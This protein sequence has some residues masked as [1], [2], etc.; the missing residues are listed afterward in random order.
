MTI[1][2]KNPGNVTFSE[3]HGLTAAD[4]DGDWH[5]GHR[6]RQA[7]LGA[8]GE[9]RRSRSD[10]RAGALHLQDRARIR[11]RPAAR[12][13]C[14]SSCTTVRAPARRIQTADLNKDGA[15]DIMTGTQARDVRVPGYAASGR[16]GRARTGPWRSTA[17]AAESRA[18]SP[19]TTVSKAHAR[20]FRACAASACSS[21]AAARGSA[22]AWSARSRTRRRTSRS[23]T[24]TPRRRPL[25]RR[26]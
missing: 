18:S 16:P 6:H 21:P 17:I 11:R 26:T 24:S 19:P 15:M 25:S 5:S 9:L 8:S 12:S 13:S 1:R 10:G 3:L 14:P 7:L 20:A 4:M 23:S 2:P 22:P